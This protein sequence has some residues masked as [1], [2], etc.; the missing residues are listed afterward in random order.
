M[1]PFTKSRIH[2]SVLGLS[3]YLKQLFAYFSIYLVI[4]IILMFLVLCS[5]RT[6]IR[7]LVP[8]DAWHDLKLRN[9]RPVAVVI[10]DSGTHYSSNTDTQH[11]ARTG[12][13]MTGRA[14][15]GL[16]IHDKGTASLGSFGHAMEVAD[17]CEDI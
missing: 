14:S 2:P 7:P 15:A 1:G 10:L 3:V 16:C 8:P 5:A 17:S 12:I 9:S 6:S 11:C 4:F 13:Q